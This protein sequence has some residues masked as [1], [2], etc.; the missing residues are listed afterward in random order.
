MD[1]L[2]RLFSPPAPSRN[3]LPLTVECL[4][5]GEIITGAVNLNSEVSPDYGEDGGGELTYVCRKLLT[6]KARCFQQ[7]EV[8]LHFDASRKVTDKQITGGKFV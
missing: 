1:F 7:I 4:R 6:G 8:I 5:C 3:V 2:R